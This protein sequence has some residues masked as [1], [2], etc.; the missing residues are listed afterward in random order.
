MGND[1]KLS[2]IRLEDNGT[3]GAPMY[4]RLKLG[5]MKAIDT[6]IYAPGERLPSESAL[7]RHCN[8]SRTTVVR[9]MVDLEKAGYVVRR[10]GTGT[11]ARERKIEK[12]LFALE[13]FSQEMRR[14]LYSA[15]SKVLS[16]ERTQ[17]DPEHARLLRLPS[18]AEVHVIR[19]IRMADLR[20]AVLETL[21]LP[22]AL[23]PNLEDYF[24]PSCQSLYD[25]AKRVYGIHV[26]NAEFTVEATNL[27]ATEARQ[28]KVQGG[29]TAALVVTGVSFD[30]AQRSV[31]WSRSLYPGSLYRFVGHSSAMPGYDR[32]NPTLA[33]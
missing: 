25:L 15:S 29:N 24:D 1:A 28:L 5:L 11:F 12:V 16:F 13:G 27:S 7:C 10:Q 3:L 23:F 17:C 32:D 2:K 30:D 20:P 4:E 31:E 26:A 18:E 22:V 9:A 6:G 8:T 21:E 14:N 33:P 19:R